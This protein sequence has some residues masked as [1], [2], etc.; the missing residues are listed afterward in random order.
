MRRFAAI[1]ALWLLGLS[2]PA[3]ASQATLVTPGTPLSMSG[4]ASFLNN[5][6]LSIGSCNSG[7]SAPANGTG[8]AAFTQECWANTTST[9]WLFAYYDGAQWVRFG[10]LNSTAHAWLIDN[11]A[12]GSVT[13]APGAFT[14][15]AASAPSTQTAN[16]SQANGDSAIIFNGSGTL[17]LTL[18]AASSFPGRLLFVK[19]IASQAVNSASSNVVPIGSSSAGTSILAATAGK[20]AILQSDGTNW[21]IMAAN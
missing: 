2:A 14:S 20:W 18:Q 7:T 6:L 1:A 4:L 19:T 10:S 9:T 21:I 17:T 13:P 8:S 16:Y 15:L 3:L 12:I 11:V 5:A